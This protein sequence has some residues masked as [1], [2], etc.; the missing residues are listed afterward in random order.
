MPTC[1]GGAAYWSRFRTRPG[2][3]RRSYRARRYCSCASR[4]TWRSAKGLWLPSPRRGE[5]RKEKTPAT[6]KS[7]G[8]IAS[9]FRPPGL[10]PPRISALAT[11]AADDAADGGKGLIGVGAQGRDGRDAHHDDQGQHDGVLDRG[12]AVFRLEEID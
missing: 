9:R 2:G 4:G 3:S 1:T 7:A 12:R 8:V 5:G 11:G 10:H 6:T